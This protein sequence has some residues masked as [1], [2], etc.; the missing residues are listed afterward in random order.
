MCLLVGITCWD[1]VWGDICIYSISTWVK[2]VQKRT[3]WHNAGRIFSDI[4]NNTL[5]INNGFQSW[6]FIADCCHSNHQWFLMLNSCEPGKKL[7]WI[8]YLNIFCNFVPPVVRD[9]LIT[10]YAIQHS[11]G[12]SRVIHSWGML[13]L[14]MWSIENIVIFVWWNLEIVKKDGL[15]LHIR[16]SPERVTK[17]SVLLPFNGNHPI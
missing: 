12:L 9:W 3:I 7:P 14:S 13:E 17:M 6:F 4:Y 11:A 10:I 8:L 1:G 5:W 16:F 15:N 2:D